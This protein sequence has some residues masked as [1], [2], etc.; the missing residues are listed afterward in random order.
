M[1]DSYKFPPLDLLRKRPIFRVYSDRMIVELRRK[2]SLICEANGI[3]I[4]KIYPMVIGPSV[5]YF[6]VVFFED[7]DIDLIRDYLADDIIFRH[8]RIISLYSGNQLI[9]IE[10]PRYDRDV[11]DLR[12]V[13]ETKGFQNFIGKL[14]IA[15]GILT[16]NNK[17][18]GCSLISLPHLL[19][20]GGAGTGKSTVLHCIILSLLYSQTPKELK[21]ILIDTEN[22]TFGVYSKIR[23]QYL[24][25]NDGVE[26][27]IITSEIHAVQTLYSLCEEMDRRLTTFTVSGVLPY[28]VIVIDEFSELMMKYGKFFE[29]PLCHLAQMGHKVGIHLVIATRQPN[30]K[31]ISQFIKSAFSTRILC[32]LNSTEGSRAILDTTDAKFLTGNGDMLYSS[33]GNLKRVQGCFVNIIEIE[34]VCNWIASNNK[35]YGQDHIQESNEKDKIMAGL[36]KQHCID[37]IIDNEKK[38]M[39]VIK[40]LRECACP[41]ES[42]G[43][44]IDIEESPVSNIDSNEKEGYSDQPEN[45]K[46]GEDSML[47]KFWYR[48]RNKKK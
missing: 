38:S 36:S 7:I 11:V 9:A 6:E 34:R 13:L 18:F 42:S 17:L 45:K 1:T 41:I 44:S 16:E 10:V 31:V 23:E 2:V 15:L 3:K 28:L 12:G 30:D 29:I 14:P 43:K 4:K 20:C 8:V 47:K 5:Y 37:E 35:R 26:K 46:K 19:I 39:D 48:M 24:F 25:D 33:D 40:F 32:K 27:S 22:E 21:L